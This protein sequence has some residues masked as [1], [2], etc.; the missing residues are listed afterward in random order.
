[1]TDEKQD[2]CK[3][4]CELFAD[5]ILLGGEA[6][7]VC[8]CAPGITRVIRVPE[9]T[10]PSEMDRAEGR[11]SSAA[12]HIEEA[13]EHILKAARG[14]AEVID[15]VSVMC[16]AAFTKEEV[17]RI[18]GPPR[19]FPVSRLAKLE[20]SLSGITARLDHAAKEQRRS[21]IAIEANATSIANLLIET[22]TAERGDD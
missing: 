6:A 16:A 22:R 18:V 2:A 1:M 9:Q 7:L 5:M 11:M 20:S 21:A 3:R 17:E 12:E 19:P 13:Q 15:P 4:G 10:A 14:E 8:D